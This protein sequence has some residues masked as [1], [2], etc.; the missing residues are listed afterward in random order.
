MSGE[1][2]TGLEATVAALSADE[3][4]VF[5]AMKAQAMP[6]IDAALLDLMRAMTNTQVAVAAAEID[7]CIAIVELHRWK[8]ETKRFGWNEALDAVVVALRDWK[9][10][11]SLPD[12]ADDELEIAPSVLPST[13]E[14]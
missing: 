13:G 7:R 3:A 8:A 11:S 6:L 12:T 14:S 4:A 2:D 9:V 10:K 5:A 1:N